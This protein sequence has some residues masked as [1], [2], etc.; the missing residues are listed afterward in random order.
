MNN[1]WN[2]E[3]SENPQPPQQNIPVQTLEPPQE[4]IS[5][6][7]APSP[8]NSY[9]PNSDIRPQQYTGYY[10]AYVPVPPVRPRKSHKAL[11]ITLLS[12]GGVILIALT[13]IA[14]YYF[15]QNMTHQMAMNQCNSIANEI[16]NGNYTNAAD[17][18]GEMNPDYF[19]Y[20]K[21]TVINSFTAAVASQ[22]LKSVDD[23]NDSTIKRFRE[24]KYLEEKIGDYSV[25]SGKVRYYIDC[26]LQLEK[27]LQYDEFLA[28]VNSKEFDS[29]YTQMSAFLSILENYGD[30]SGIK[31]VAME[32]G[33]L[34]LTKYGKNDSEVQKIAKS[35]D[36]VADGIMDVYNGF[37]YANDRMAQ[38]GFE[39]ALDELDYLDECRE[40][41]DKIVA[42]KETAFSTL[43]P[44][45]FQLTE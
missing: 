38:A 27:Y 5:P 12:I 2:Y 39:Q 6:P 4:N 18:I 30:I 42:D 35:K 28:C 37:V 36:K 43:P 15:Q 16:N 29:I 3:P 45:S 34:S 1:Q 17:M 10:P 21:K 9:Y 44:V 11:L 31:Q 8:G 33:S 23:I 25:S 32:I 7:T 13:A 20:G 22:S 14:I 41:R 19:E 26:V 40:R 24:L